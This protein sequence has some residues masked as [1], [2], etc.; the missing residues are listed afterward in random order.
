MLPRP[1]GALKTL[2]AE[3]SGEGPGA[4]APQIA[5]TPVL[6]E[7]AYIPAKPCST[8]AIPRVAGKRAKPV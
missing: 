2:D 8:F 7:N 6:T 5:R 3:G 4:R 1:E